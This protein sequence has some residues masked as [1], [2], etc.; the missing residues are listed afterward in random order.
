MSAGDWLRKLVF[1]PARAH[2][3]AQQIEPRIKHARLNTG[4]DPKKRNMC[5]GPRPP[6]FDE[7]KR[8]ARA[9]EWYQ[10]WDTSK[11]GG[12]ISVRKAT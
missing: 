8:V 9:Q 6:L 11:A 12:N 4:G 5:C 1:L 3:K 2:L 10:D 7:G